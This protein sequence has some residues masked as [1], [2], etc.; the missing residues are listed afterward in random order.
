MEF[1]AI[2]NSYFKRL[3]V[4]CSKSYGLS[5]EDAEDMVQEILLKVYKN[6]DTYAE[7]HAVSTWIYTIARNTCIDFLRKSQKPRPVEMDIDKIIQLPDRKNLNPEETS[8]KG[9]LRSLIASFIENLP[10]ND[11]ELVF[12]KM[13]EDLPYREISAITGRP[14]GT[15]KYRFSSIRKQLRQFLGESSEREKLA[16]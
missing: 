13:F 10:E 11:R 14:T 5:D 3:Y 15:I 4:F 6:R 9:E 2:W 12:L 16:N 8:T 1:E 7:K